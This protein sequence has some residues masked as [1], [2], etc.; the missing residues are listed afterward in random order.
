MTGELAPAR[1]V[2]QRGY[3]RRNQDQISHMMRRPVA[4]S[5]PSLLWSWRSSHP[6]NRT[7]AS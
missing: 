4:A 6:A 1:H 7:W 5:A 2:F 3:R